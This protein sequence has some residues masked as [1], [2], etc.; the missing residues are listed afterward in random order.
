MIYKLMNIFV[1]SEKTVYAYMHS[2]EKFARFF[3]KSPD[4]ITTD[5]IIKYQ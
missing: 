4:K 1:K 2:M 5:E 3:N